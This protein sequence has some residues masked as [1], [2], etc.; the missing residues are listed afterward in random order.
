M[1]VVVSCVHVALFNFNSLE[2]HSDRFGVGR[3]GGNYG[4]LAGN[5]LTTRT[6]LTSTL[7]SRSPWSH[8]GKVLEPY[9]DPDSKIRL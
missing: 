4:V 7:E 1:C 5:G 8:E 3:L 9:E 6:V 2:T